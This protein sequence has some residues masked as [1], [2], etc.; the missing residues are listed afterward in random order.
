MAR[1]GQ[2]FLEVSVRDSGIGIPYEDQDKLFKLFGFVQ[3]TAQHNKNGVGLGLV[4]SERIEKQLG[5][6]IG[7][8]SRPSPE[9]DHGSTFYFTIALE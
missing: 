8:T 6:K 2:E 1:Q 9:Q 7:F 4:I 5:G 3:S